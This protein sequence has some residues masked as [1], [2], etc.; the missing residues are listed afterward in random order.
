ML[1]QLLE[2]FVRQKQQVIGSHAELIVKYLSAT[3]NGEIFTE[4]DVEIERKESI[5]KGLMQHAIILS[6]PKIPRQL[7]SKQLQC[8]EQARP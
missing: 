6:S 8:Q 2:H 7:P 4:E 5:E 1:Q 3:G